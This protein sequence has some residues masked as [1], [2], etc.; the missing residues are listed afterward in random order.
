MLRICHS[1][2][3][4]HRTVLRC[5]LHCKTHHH[6][7]E[8]DCHRLEILS[9][10]R[11][12]S[13]LC[14]HSMLRMDQ[15][16]RQLGK[17]HHCRML[18]FLMPGRHRKLRRSQ[19]P[20]CHTFSCG[21]EFHH[22]KFLNTHQMLSTYPSFHPLGK[23]FLGCKVRLR[24]L[25]QHMRLHR[26]K[27]Q[28]CC[29]IVFSSSHRSHRSSSM[30]HNHS[31]L[32]N[33]HQSPRRR[34]QCH[35]RPTRQHPQHTMHHRSMELGCHRPGFA[36]E[37][38]HHMMR[39]RRCMLQKL[40]SFHRQQRYMLECCIPSLQLHHR[41]ME[42]HRC[43][44]VGCHMHVTCFGIHLHMVLNMSTMPCTGRT[45]RALVQEAEQHQG[46]RL[47]QG[48]LK[49]NLIQSIHRS[50]Q[51]HRLRLYHQPFDPVQLDQHHDQLRSPTLQ[52]RTHGCR[53]PQQPDLRLR[54]QVFAIRR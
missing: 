35:R 10:F 29:T 54:G 20:G 41:H 3:L 46:C 33:C 43:W 17:P 48:W 23:G 40:P 21:R 15:T 14:M 36:F 53:R 8:L 16:F 50:L 39:S 32:P 52:F 38:H 24:W 34:H 7:R 6:W 11:C 42:V 27:G 31:N 2:L 13:S 22:R 51:Q 28:G 4:Y 9:A 26:L 44:E 18:V 1:R 12:H 37:C 47:I 25:H 30:L 45:L 49:R 5:R 19:V